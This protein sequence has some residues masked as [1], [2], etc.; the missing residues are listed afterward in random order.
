[1]VLLEAMAFKKTIVTMNV[2]SISEIVIDEQ[3]GFLV[4]NELG[5]FINKIKVSKGNK[6][7]RINLGNRAFDYVNEKYNIV[8]YV[9]KIEEIYNNIR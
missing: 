6:N 4:E 2:G 3:T 5:K 9:S 8:N 7:L 1:M